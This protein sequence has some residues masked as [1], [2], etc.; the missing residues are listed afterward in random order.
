MRVGWLSWV[1]CREGRVQGGHMG[2]PFTQAVPTACMQRVECLHTVQLGLRREGM[3]KDLRME[4][5]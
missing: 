1:V 5:I 2:Q 3:P 4:C